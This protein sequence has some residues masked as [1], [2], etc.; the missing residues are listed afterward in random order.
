MGVKRRRHGGEFKA[1]V[2]VEAIKVR[3]TVAEVASR[4]GVHPQQVT[5]WKRQALDGI[6]EIFSSRRPHYP[7]YTAR[8]QSRNQSLS[9]YQAPF[10]YAAFWVSLRAV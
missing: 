8:L 5:S 1:K 7:C 4:F 2:A 9:G 10:L 6:P 3:A